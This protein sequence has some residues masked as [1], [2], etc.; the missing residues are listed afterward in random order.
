MKLEVKQAGDDGAFVVFGDVGWPGVIIETGDEKWRM[1]ERNGRLYITEHR[2]GQF[3]YARSVKDFLYRDKAMDEKTPVEIP[4]SRAKPES[5]YPGWALP[6]L[7]Q[8]LI[9]VR[10]AAKCLEGIH[11]DMAVDIEDDLRILIKELEDAREHDKSK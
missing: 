8:A 1:Y 2:K 6:Y 5:P 3:A 7:R 4:K 9:F 10:D 11:S